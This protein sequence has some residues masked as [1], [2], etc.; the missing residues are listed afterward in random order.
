MLKWNYNRDTFKLPIVELHVYVSKGWEEIHIYTTNTDVI[1][2][3]NL[4]PYST[5]QICFT[6]LT[7]R[8]SRNSRKICDK[9]DPFTTAEGGLSLLFDFVVKTCLIDNTCLWLRLSCFGLL[10]YFQGGVLHFE[11]RSQQNKIIENMLSGN[12]EMILCRDSK[13]EK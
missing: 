1:N 5:Y 11:E 6:P 4:E 3:T 7:F 9:K 10:K 12:G 8:S 2:I 13:L